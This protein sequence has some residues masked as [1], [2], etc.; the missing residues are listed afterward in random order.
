MPEFAPNKQFS[1]ID[2]FVLLPPE[3]VPI[4]L[5]PPPRSELFPTITPAEILPSI[6]AFPSVPALK[7]T[8]P[9]CITVVPSLKYAPNLTLLVSAI[10]TFFGIM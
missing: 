1:P 4:V 2:I 3:S 5:E 9:S 10:L 6:I 8:K 7:F